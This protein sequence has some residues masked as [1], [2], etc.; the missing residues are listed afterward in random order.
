MTIV[1]AVLLSATLPSA[2]E[3]ELRLV[4]DKTQVALGELA[5]CKVELWNRSSKPINLPRP[6]PNITVWFEITAFGA[7]H[8]PGR[9]GEDFVI[10]PMERIGPGKCLSV[11]GQVILWAPEIVERFDGRDNQLVV[12]GAGLFSGLKLYS[13][14]VTFTVAGKAAARDVL[15]K[16]YESPQ[17]RW[18]TYQAAGSPADWKTRIDSVYMCKLPYQKVP[19]PVLDHL[20]EEF[21]PESAAYRVVAVTAHLEAFCAETILFRELEEQLLAI[22]R[23]SGPAERLWLLQAA[24]GGLEIR[25]KLA[26]ARRLYDLDLEARLGDMLP[27]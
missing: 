9:S 25:G 4:F 17:R 1:F 22:L 27:P 21:R 11:A 15:L 6:F 13:D 14:P 23:T 12:K 20:M 10:G 18:Q 24:G 5:Y 3:I 19:E 2:D 26:E 16:L 8:M 7:V